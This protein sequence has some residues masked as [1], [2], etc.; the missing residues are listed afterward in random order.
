MSTMSRV[1][2]RSSIA[3]RRRDGCRTDGTD[4]V[5]PF[6]FIRTYVQPADGELFV[7]LKE[8]GSSRAATT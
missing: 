6:R 3:R 5:E 2:A 1:A 8:W 4:R 7:K